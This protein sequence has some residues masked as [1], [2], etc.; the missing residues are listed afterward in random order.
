MTAAE[1]YEAAGRLKEESREQTE[2][3]WEDLEPY[4]TKTCEN[5]GFI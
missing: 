2:R 3:M 1:R 5:P 4:G